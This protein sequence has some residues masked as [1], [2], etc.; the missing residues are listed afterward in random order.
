[1]SALDERVGSCLPRSFY[2]RSTPLVA[3]SLLGKL[4][5]HESR[6]GLTVGRIVEVE[7][8]LARDPASHAFRGMT[9]RNAAMFGE[10]GHAYVYGI[11]GMHRCFN[12]VTRAPGV[13]EAVLVRALEPLA[14]VE[15]MRAR[16]GRER[17]HE[18]CSGPGKL[19]QAFGIEQL[20]DKLDLC[21]SQL[22]I[23]EPADGARIKT[24]DVVRTTRIGITRAAEL[25]LRFYL[26]GHAH[27]S[28]R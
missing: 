4:L 22:R 16:R 17:L 2:A 10:A 28:K 13:G 19:V 25:D 21:A 1:M 14:G 27:V 8:Y 6:D 15:L 5:V 18:L 11:Y 20:H 26:R 7:A 9:A 12:V 24:A 3:R 23:H